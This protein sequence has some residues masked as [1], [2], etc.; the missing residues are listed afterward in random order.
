MQPKTQY[1]PVYYTSEITPESLTRIY[2]ALGRKAQG[3]NV[4]VKISTGESNKSNHLDTALIRDFVKMVNGTIIECNTAYGG[5]RS[6]TANH[7]RGRREH[8]FTSVGPRRHNGC[9]RQ[10]QP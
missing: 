5:N 1:Q 3:R 7:L 10:T 4:A 8:G 9:R 2:E 6:E